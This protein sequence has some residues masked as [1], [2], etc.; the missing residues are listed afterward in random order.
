MIHAA[1]DGELPAADQR[2][3]DIYLAN[4]EEGRAYKASL[5]KLHSLL[6]AQGEAPT[7]GDSGALARGIQQTKVHP[8]RPGARNTLL[9][10][11]ASLVLGV[12]LLMVGN[13]MDIN[14]MGESAGT[15]APRS[16]TEVLTF[17]DLNAALSIEWQG[18]SLVILIA[19]QSNSNTITTVTYPE[20]ELVP[21]IPSARVRVPGVLVI[22]SF[23]DSKMVARLK[24]LEAAQPEGSRL[25]VAFSQAGRVVGSTELV[26]PPDG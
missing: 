11:A 18:P 3:L 10:I 1:F 8:R 24:R 23:G 19:L 12:S 26:V 21:V 13:I 25:T 7:A 2:A 20:N 22:E 16:G 9:A 5:E 14:D 6:K 17:P 4:S 15:M